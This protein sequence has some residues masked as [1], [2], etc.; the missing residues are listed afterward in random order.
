MTPYE[1]LRIVIW[2]F[3]I[4]TIIALTIRAAKKM[5]AIRQRHEELLTEEAANPRS[6]LQALSELYAEPQK[7]KRSGK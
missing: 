2:V 7:Q 4:P 5:R 1:N 3:G 6:S